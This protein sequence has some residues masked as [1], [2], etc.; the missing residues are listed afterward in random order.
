M[1]LF[2]AFANMWRGF[3]SLFIRDIAVANPEMAYEGIIQQRKQERAR[4]VEAAGAVVAERNKRAA[5]LANTEQQLVDVERKLA[6]AVRLNDKDVGGLL[7]QQK[8]NLEKQR[9]TLKPQV[10]QLNTHV[11]NVKQDIA[12]YN[13][14]L[15]ALQQEAKVN[16]ARLRSAQAQK[17]IMDMIEGL[18]VRGDDQM[19][20]SIRDSVEQQ[21][22]QVE[23]MKEID[24]SGN[25][26][27]RLEQVSKAAEKNVA[28]D[29]FARLRAVF[30]SSQGV[31]E[32]KT[33]ASDGNAASG[34]QV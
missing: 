7:I 20:S 11:E 32:A 31:Q 24:E 29:E 21:V 9:D 3:V 16:V 34:K 8:A 5:E 33:P 27:R 13:R 2:H 10:E 28:D 25:L 22:G 12:R 15:L 4:L 26:E 17:R 14:D 23:V 30:E 18:S 6:A 1:R 19:L